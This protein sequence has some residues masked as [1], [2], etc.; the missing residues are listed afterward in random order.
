MMKDNVCAKIIILPQIHRL[1]QA[2]IHR[3]I[4][5]GW[6]PHANY[7]SSGQPVPDALTLWRFHNTDDPRQVKKRQAIDHPAEIPY[8][9]LLQRD[10]PTIGGPHPDMQQVF[11]RGEPGGPFQH[12]EVREYDGQEDGAN[13][14][15]NN[16]EMILRGHQPGAFNRIGYWKENNA[17]CDIINDLCSDSLK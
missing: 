1:G 7:N 2:G 12:N 16:P 4:Y 13:R 6:G 15:E 17:E 9:A 5:H 11:A 8:Y 10:L 3:R 14:V